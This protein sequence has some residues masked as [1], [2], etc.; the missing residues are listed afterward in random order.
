MPMHELPFEYQALPNR[1]RVVWPGE[2]RV[3]VY[4]ELNIE[5]WPVGARGLT[6]LAGQPSALDPLNYGWRDYGAR[7]GIWRVLDLLDKHR[8]VA[9]AA[10]D[11]DAC[12]LY[13]DI[14][15]AGIA[16][17]W[18]WVAH[19]ENA[20][21]LQGTLTSVSAE[22]DYLREMLV[23]IESATG[24]VPSGWLGPALTESPATI[25]LLAKL[26]LTH[27]LDWSNDDEPFALRTGDRSMVAVPRSAELS[28]VTAFVI[29]GW[30]GSQ[31]VAASIDAFDTL[32]E[33]Q[34]SGAVFGIAVHPFLFGTPSRI[35]ALD[36][37]LT[38]I[39]SRSSVWITTTHAIAECALHSSPAT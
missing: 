23:A 38:H 18:A 28:D 34:R 15:Q 10:I 17:R 11:S 26:G 31:L 9:S 4:L 30:S 7:V 19:G 5:S 27:V 39:A 1:T 13:P 3:A 20:S 22:E 14:V 32:Y 24:S 2:A 36:R 35:R 16:R 29:R 33:S 25:P 37:L 6:L 8:V 21:R 12:L